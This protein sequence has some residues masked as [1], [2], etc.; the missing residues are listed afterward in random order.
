LRNLIDCVSQLLA[1]EEI[2][3][4]TTLEIARFSPEIQEEVFNEHLGDDSYSW[5]KLQAR[6]FRRLIENAYRF[7][8][9][10]YLYNF[11]FALTVKN[12]V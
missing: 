2:T 3:L 9:L 7:E 6:D 12:C 10:L 1:G 4:T 11:V 5:K 8:F